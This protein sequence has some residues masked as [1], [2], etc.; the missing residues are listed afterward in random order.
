MCF[1]RGKKLV[2]EIEVRAAH[3]IVAARTPQLAL[4]VDQLM[5]ALQT[6]TPVLAGN[7][8][9]GWRGADFTVR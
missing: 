2:R 4:L 5:P 3:E 8:F 1:I 9:V 7:V 6:I